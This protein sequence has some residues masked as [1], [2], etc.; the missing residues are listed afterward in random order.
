MF[1]PKCKSYKCKVCNTEKQNTSFTYNWRSQHNYKICIECEIKLGLWN[2]LEKR[3]NMH[4]VFKEYQATNET[5]PAE[6]GVA[7]SNEA[8]EFEEEALQLFQEN[9]EIYN[10][11]NLYKKLR[12]QEKAIAKQRSILLR[13]LKNDFKSIFVPLFERKNPEYFL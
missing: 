11:M 3:K 10:K 2:N 5:R 7:Q 9:I 12:E 13:E 4:L 6:F 8:F 1:I